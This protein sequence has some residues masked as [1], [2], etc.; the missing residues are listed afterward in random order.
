MAL[1]PI[2]NLDSF[3]DSTGGG[4]G[5][6]LPT[7]TFT[8]GCMDSRASN[9]NPAATF[10]DGTCTFAPVEEPIANV[11]VDTEVVITC[12]SNPTNAAVFIDDLDT[13]F[14]S[15]TSFKFNSKEFLTPKIFTAKISEF[16][17]ATKFKV[18]AGRLIGTKT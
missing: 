13:G 12:I 1:A 14:K 9:Y 10:D 7:T 15:T 18:Q 8:R 4:G 3:D 17:S 11:E 16:T 5:G 6:G 2:E